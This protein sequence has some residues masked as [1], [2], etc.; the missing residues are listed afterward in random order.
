MFN[1]ILAGYQFL[2]S[3]NKF[4]K[5]NRALYY[6][7][8][9]GLGIL[10]YENYKIS[11]EQAFIKSYFSKL[12]EGVVLDI[13]AN[14]GNYTKNILK[15]SPDIKIYAFEPHP[16]TYKKLTMSVVS[17]NFFSFNFAVG[18]KNSEIQLYDYEDNDGSSH[19]SIY[20]EV[21]ECI[22]KHKSIKYDIKVIRIDNFLKEYS[23]DSIDLLKIDTEGN[24]LEVLKGLGN[25][26]LEGKIKAIHFEF[27]E[28]NVI[29][30]SFFKDFWDILPN[31]NFYRMVRDGLVP[32]EQYNPVDC[33]IYAF[34]NIVALIKDHA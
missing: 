21:I 2:F 32:I 8:L 12:K 6:L 18:S 16:I 13:G 26:I 30:R 33:E 4:Y 7:S 29:S 23:I 24:E 28:M 20:K 11:G 25:R 31:Y 14:I 9:R 5:F 27:N 22:H 34:Q 10:N 19:A 1:I 3:R 15:I 17:K